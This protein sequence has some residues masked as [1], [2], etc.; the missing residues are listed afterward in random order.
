MQLIVKIIYVT[1]TN[2]ITA[3]V[4]LHIASDG[5]KAWCVDYEVCP[6]CAECDAEMRARGYESVKYALAFRV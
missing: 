2:Y 4:L 3:V 1:I 6:V 5:E